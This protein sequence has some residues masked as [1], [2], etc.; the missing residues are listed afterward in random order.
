[1]AKS[2]EGGSLDE[3]QIRRSRLEVVSLKFFFV[4][5]FILIFTFFFD[6]DG[7]HGDIYN[8]PSDDPCLSCS[9]TCNQ[10][11]VCETVPI[12]K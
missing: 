8:C 9:T 10:S 5:S 12:G 1:M 7:V 6:V 11:W 2:R 3:Q 4:I